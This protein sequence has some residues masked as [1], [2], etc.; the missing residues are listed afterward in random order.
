[1]ENSIFKGLFDTEFTATIP[2]EHFLLCIFVALFIG[3]FVA[4]AY[5]FRTRYS[6]SFVVTL[7]LL[8]AVVSVVILMVNGNLGAGVAVAGTFSLVRFRSVPGTAKEIVSIFLAMAVGLICGMG[9][10]AFAGLFGLVLCAALLVSN[11]LDLGEK[12]QDTRYRTLR[13]TIPEELDY[14]GAFDDI[15]KEYTAACDLVQVKSVN[16]GS[17]FRLTYDVTLKKGI[18]EK[19]MLDQIRTRNAN[20]EVMLARRENTLAG[21]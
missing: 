12:R 13:I 14:S 3:V 5:A 2:V 21:L 17:L 19:E 6:K 10:L 20:L 18:N 8:P 15:F 9:Y 4:L 7:A 16:L 11:L 1:M